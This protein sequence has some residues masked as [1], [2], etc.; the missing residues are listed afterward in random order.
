[1]QIDRFLLA[2][3]SLVLLV[4]TIYF[5]CGSDSGPEIPDLSTE[6][7][8]QFELIRFE[9]E[10]FELDTLQLASAVQALEA[11]YPGFTDVFFRFVIPLRRGDFSP[12][13]QIEVLKAFLRYPLIR[14]IYQQASEQYPNLPDELG[15]VDFRRSERS[16][17]SASD[18]NGSDEWPALANALRNYAYYLPQADLPDTVTTYISQFEYA[19]FLYGDNDLAIGLDLFIGPEFN[20]RSVSVD[21]VIFSDYLTRT[22]N[23]DHLLTS[24]IRL[25][26]EEDV[27]PPRAGRL[28]DHIINNGKRLYLLDR[29]LPETPDSVFLRMTP[30]Q[31]SWC[32]T[33]ETE[34]YT[35][36]A[37]EDLLYTT[38]QRDIR[39]YVEP[40]PTSRGMPEE[41]PGEAANWLGWKIVETYMRRFD[42][43]DFEDL[44]GVEDGQ[45]ILARSGYKPPR[46]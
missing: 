7:L 14:E 23:A 31:I 1:M 25:L 30:Q 33:H 4:S 44:L 26:A 22:Y 27:P 8:P 42:D 16:T 32:E 43:K 37:R 38:D 28:I 21:E 6:P 2:I 12:E 13:E 40:A 24:A 17:S 10:L 46:R 11:K 15:R 34:I 35:W 5:G 41:S 20:Y 39:R 19:G 29:V 3:T 18:T 9:Q 36:L 45:T